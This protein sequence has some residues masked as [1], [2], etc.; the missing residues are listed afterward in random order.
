[1]K[2]TLKYALTAILGAALVVPAMAQDN[3]PDVPDNHWAYEALARLKSNGLLVGYPDGLFRGGRP[4]SRYEMAVAIHATYVNLKNITDGLQQQIDELKKQ[5]AGNNDSAALQNLRDALTALQ[6]DVNGLKGLRGDVDNLRKLADTFQKELQD[7]NVNVEQLKKDLSDI[8]DRVSAL[9]KRKTAI[10]ISGDAN[11]WVG[12]GISDDQYGLSKDGRIVGAQKNRNGSFKGLA[13]FD[14]DLTV[15]HEGALTFTTTKETGPKFTGTLV[16]G[17]ALG[18]SANYGVTGFGQ[19][20]NSTAFGDQSRTYAGLGYNEGDS[21]IYLQHFAVKFDTSLAG[22]ALNAEIGRVG[23]KVSPYVFQRADNTSYLD[24][25]RWDN[26]KVLL[27]GGIVGFNL[28]GAK[29][30]IVG[31]V[32]S[33]QTTSNGKLISPLYAGALGGEFGGLGN[34][35]GQ[36]PTPGTNPSPLDAT[37]ESGFRVDRVLG[38]SVNLPL[39]SSGYL[40]VSYLLLDSDTGY[41]GLTTTVGQNQVKVPNNRVGTFGATAKFDLSKITVEGGYASTVLN[42]NND[43]VK[44]SDKNNQAYFGKLSYGSDKF[45]IDGGYR[46]VEANFVAAGDWGRLG[47]LRNPT[48]IEGFQT[49]AHLHLGDAIKLSAKGE[50]DKGHKDDFATTT[51][52]SKDTKINSFTLGLDYKLSSTLSLLASYEDTKFEKATKPAG[53]PAD[54][55]QYKWTTFGIGYGLSETAKLKIAYEISDIKSDYFIPQSYLA[56][57]NGGRYKGGFITT[58]LTVKF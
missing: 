27:D 10:D 16:I 58:Q 39:T 20:A 5:I 48:N 17:N 6:N 40:N 35:F 36:N 43:K 57:G 22:L 31:G 13:G 32:T 21:D 15:L 23:Y 28:G 9:E 24:N 44:G 55:A 7:L 41:T 30:D 33:N 34:Q 52:F 38:A 37:K 3:F 25:E 56:G 8:G 42:F 29:I 53:S 19:N 45:G 51:S 11:I 47:V 18:G 12:G 1:M 14:K 54:D 49:N 50:F 46:V 2:R 4:A 26:G